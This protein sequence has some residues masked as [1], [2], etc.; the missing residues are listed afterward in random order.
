MSSTYSKPLSICALLSGLVALS[1]CGES[2]V[3]IYDAPKDAPRAAAPAAAAMASPGHLHWEKAPGW[4]DLA[5]TAFRKGN[6]L[7]S[8]DALGPVE[9]TVSSFPGEVGG[10]LANVN[11][12]LGQA[13]LP[14]VSQDELDRVTTTRSVDG[15]DVAVVDLA[16]AAAEP[17]DARIYAAVTLFAGQSWFFKMAGP[18]AAV[19]SQIEA[20]DAMLGELT[21]HEDAD[22]A[23]AS[24][25]APAAQRPAAEIVFEAPIGWVEKPGSSIRVASYEIARNGLPP[26]DFSLTSFPGDTGGLAANVNRW[27]AQIGLPGWSEAQTQ[28]RGQKLS[29]NGREFLFFDLKAETAAEK[30]QT[31]ERILAAILQRDGRS[32]FFKLRGDAVL[33]ET[34]R[35]NFLALLDTVSFGQAAQ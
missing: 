1:G 35:N 23:P 16:G 18:H 33:L 28:Q 2:E 7:Y 21:F 19:E 32:W 10:L 9:I 26:A 29:K 6:Y 31:S 25:A 17:S 14:P 24:A 13:G 22:D 20:F 4:Q 12:W 34:Q 30:A 11:R 8:G 27:R 5:P 3:R 15:R